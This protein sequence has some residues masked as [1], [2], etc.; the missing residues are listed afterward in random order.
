[1]SLR[2]VNET[3]VDDVDITAA[4]ML[5]SVGRGIESEDDLE[6]VL[7]LATSL[8]VPLSA[9]RPIIDAAG[10]RRRARSASPVR[11]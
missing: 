7:E 2:A 6:V 4:E 8:E 1:M 9:S 3:P 11:R 10:C 5:V